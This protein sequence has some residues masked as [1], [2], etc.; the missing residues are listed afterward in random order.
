[1]L[2]GRIRK[3]GVYDDCWHIPGGGIEKGEAKETALVREVQEE[4]GID[5][6]N[7][8][9]KLLSDTDSAQAIKR[10]K[11]TREEHLVTM[12]FHDYQIDLPTNANEVR[13]SLNDDLEKY[14]W[15]PLTQLQKYKHTPPS[16]KLFSSLG[17]I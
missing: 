3:G 10:D 1:M 16:L 2:L 7:L 13:V 4:V 11:I 9:T 17:W 14:A 5:I 15:V 6:R 8:P 12:H